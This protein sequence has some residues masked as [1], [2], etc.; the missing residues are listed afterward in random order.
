MRV[1]K[2]PSVD[3]AVKMR[4]DHGPVKSSGSVPDGTSFDKPVHAMKSDSAATEAVGRTV[5]DVGST[6]LGEAPVSG[7]PVST[8]VGT[9]STVLVVESG[10][11]PR[12]HAS[13]ANI[14]EPIA[15]RN[16]L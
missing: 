14:D 12:L 15:T 9:A 2:R 7:T 4:V 3:V 11:L 13:A 10:A 8:R 5:I 6:G 16:R 1:H